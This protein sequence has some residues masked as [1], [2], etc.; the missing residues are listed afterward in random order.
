MKVWCFGRTGLQ[1]DKEQ[2][3]GW[4]KR[5]QEAPQSSSEHHSAQTRS[6]STDWHLSVLSY[7]PSRSRP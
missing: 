6:V 4:C 5:R 1:A 3:L 7:A 2:S